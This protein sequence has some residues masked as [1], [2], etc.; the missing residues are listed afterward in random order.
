MASHTNKPPTEAGTEAEVDHS[1]QVTVEHITVRLQLMVTDLSNRLMDSLPLRPMP[2]PNLTRGRILSSNSG[3]PNRASHTTPRHTHSHTSILC[4]PNPIQTTQPNPTSSRSSRM[5][6]RNHMPRPRS[7]NTASHT[8]IPNRSMGPPRS[9]GAAISH[10]L[11]TRDSSVAP[12]VD[13]VAM[14]MAA[15]RRLR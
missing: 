11:K 5:A 4:R 14:A 2:L 3:I 13:V 10:H 12:V 15:A 1:I 7:L 6:S 8:N 9:S